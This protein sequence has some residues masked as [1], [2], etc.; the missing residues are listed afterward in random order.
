MERIV[1]IGPPGAG[2]TTFAKRLGPIH[3]IGIYHLDRIFWR[4]GW[5]RIA[6]EKRIDILQDIVLQRKLW[7][8]EGSYLKS[9]EP[10]LKAADTIIFLDFPPIL[11][12][13]RIIERHYKDSGC[14]R[15]DLPIDCTD[16]LS[17]VRVLKVII[18]PLT[19]RITIKKKLN[20]YKNKEIIILRSFKEV[21]NFLARQHESTCETVVSESNPV[22][23]RRFALSQIPKL[24]LQY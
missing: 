17:L 22:L 9:S 16:R 15:R 10:R 1:I 18:F 5:K 3:R 12:L 23:A 4:R 6:R 21:E 19:E 24:S 8:I 14:F 7:I 2:K 20:S 13:K 11:C